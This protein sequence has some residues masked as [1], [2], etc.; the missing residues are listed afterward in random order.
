MQLFNIQSCFRR[1]L[2]R[3]SELPTAPRSVGGREDNIEEVTRAPLRRLLQGIPLP[4]HNRGNR[5][6]PALCPP[7]VSPPVSGWG[8]RCWHCSPPPRHALELRRAF[9]RGGARLFTCPGVSLHRACLGW[10]AAY[11]SCHH[12]PPLVPRARGARVPPSWPQSHGRGCS[13]SSHPG[14]PRA[15]ELPWDRG[16][17]P[18]DVGCFPGNV[19]CSPR[20]MGWFPGD[21]QGTGGGLGVLCTGLGTG[22]TAQLLLWPFSSGWQYCDLQRGSCQSNVE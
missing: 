14:L 9:A 2:G 19:G 18:R 16:C 13:L 8:L 6:L 10:A 5:G 22:G 4:G 7:S 15:R 11:E 3:G 17:S 12:H 1:R 20:D 21:A